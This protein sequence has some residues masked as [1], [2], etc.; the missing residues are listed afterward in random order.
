MEAW[1]TREASEDL[2]ETQVVKHRSLIPSN[3]VLLEVSPGFFLKPVGEPY[4][5]TATPSPPT[6]SKRQ[7]F[8]PELYVSAPDVWKVCVHDAIRGRR[9]ASPNSQAVVS[10]DG[11]YTY[12]ELDE[13]S[14]QVASMLHFI[15]AKP[16]KFIP[17][18]MDKS[19]WVIVALLAIMKS[20]AAFT[21]L[22]PA[23]PLKRIE[24]ICAD[25]SCY[26]ILSD[27]ARSKPLSTIANVICVEQALSAWHAQSHSQ[28]SPIANPKNALYVSFTSG[29]TGTPKGVMVEHRAYC[30]GARSRIEA[31][32]IDQTSRVLQFAS[33]AFDVSIME[34]LSTLMAGGCWKRNTSSFAHHLRL[35]SVRRG[36]CVAILLERS[37]WALVAILRALRAGAACVLLDPQHPHQRMQDMISDASARVL[38]TSPSLSAAAG[39]LCPTQIQ[40]SPQLI[41]TLGKDT[42]QP[43]NSDVD[44]AFILFTS[45]STGRP[46]GIVMTHRTIS[47][48]I[49]SHGSECN[50][51][52]FEGRPIQ[53]I[54]ERMDVDLHIQIV[55]VRSG[56]DLASFCKSLCE[57]EQGI[58]VC[59]SVV[60]TR[61]S[62]VSDSVCQQHVFIMR[63]SHAQ[64]DGF[65]VPRVVADLEAL[66]NGRTSFLTPTHFETYLSQLILC[67]STAAYG[68]WREYL[69]GSSITT[70]PRFQTLESGESASILKE[71]ANV[72]LPPLPSNITLVTLI[73]AS[74][75]IVL[76]RTTG[77][78]D[79]VFGHTVGGRASPIPGIDQ[80]AG[81]CLNYSPY[82][83]TLQPD[84]TV[85]EYLVYAQA[86]YTRSV[87]YETLW[88]SQIVKDCTTWTANTEF[89]FIVQHQKIK[90]GLT[91]SLRNTRSTWFFSM[92]RL[93]PGS[94]IWICFTPSMTGVDIDVVAS[95]SRMVAHSAHKMA[96]DIGAIMVDISLG[97]RRPLRR[98]GG[99]KWPRERN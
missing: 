4:R 96:H 93:F 75:A 72:S 82:R 22:D 35:L 56:K 76:A 97:L 28:L 91:L 99:L 53:L 69:S 79:L 63:L 92:G 50:I 1:Q 19:R 15:G 9:R 57:A 33:H 48:S 34:T 64:Y 70:F 13:L 21:L 47:S 94:K 26:L 80:L 20:G 95:S 23:Y 36:T 29:S 71:T 31:F 78:L 12:R 25:L 83:V 58:G 43:F 45:G 32:R 46:K 87:P 7:G 3:S 30:S 37:K 10:W 24:S 5:P 84:M 61:F 11:S 98:I 2:E 51:V 6:S 38:I 41:E 40:M 66:Y 16:E 49:R 44:P 85:L 68:F 81:P 17:I 39:A 60:P 42:S 27:K 67:Q 62:L 89:D 8:T 73:K 90:T 59:E 52:F 86:Q 77:Q 74:F 14:V 88:L 54:M 18:C 65:Y 55:I